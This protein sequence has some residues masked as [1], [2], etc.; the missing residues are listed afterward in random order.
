V[1]GA[2]DTAAFAAAVRREWAPRVAHKYAGPVSAAERDL[3]E[4]LSG[5]PPRPELAGHP[6]H[7]HIDLLPAYQRQGHGRALIRRLLATL[8]GAGVPAVHLGMVPANTAARVF[9]DRLGF[10]E[11]PVP[12]VPTVTYL[13]RPTA[14]LP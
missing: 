4:V 3:L 12:A 14:P 5:P 2:R 13:G 7:L 10:R 1:V 11:I 6:A 9:Y 8:A